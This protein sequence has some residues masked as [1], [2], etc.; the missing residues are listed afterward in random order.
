MIREDYLSLQSRAIDSLKEIHDS[1]AVDPLNF[2]KRRKEKRNLMVVSFQEELSFLESNLANLI[3]LE[4]YRDDELAAI[5]AEKAAA[6]ERAEQEKA[7]ELDAALQ[8][9]EQ[10][11]QEQKEQEQ[12]KEKAVA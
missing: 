10:Q 11:R 6:I 7:A 8:K 12:E 1:I 3:Q 2:S 5:A 9:V 4:K